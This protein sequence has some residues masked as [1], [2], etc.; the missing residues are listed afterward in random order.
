MKKDYE[1]KYHMLEDKHWW[2]EARRDMIVRLLKNDDKS[3]KI[4]EVGCSGG[5]LI[6]VL[7]R[8]G[9]KNVLGVDISEDAIDLCK[10][11]NMSDVFVMDAT[12]LKFENEQF[13][14]VI[15]SDLLEHIKDEEM[16]ISEWHRILKPGGKLI[17]FVPAFGF[18][19]SKHDEAN[20]H[21]RRY[22]KAQLVGI[23]E[24]AHFELDRSSYWNFILFFPT[25]LIR[26]L[27]AVLL[28]GKGSEDD[29]LIELD[30][31]SNKV[32]TCL[33]KMENMILNAVNFPVGVS[34][35]AITRKEKAASC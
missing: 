20:Q 10:R 21:Y 27:Q 28:R 1:I 24:R 30:S 35:F 7:R 3:V 17:V 15:T 31:V 23:L 13:D 9:Y 19:W 4:L 34:V 8:I 29:Q 25:S 14:I 26:L 22:S 12:K 33:V 16:A 5:V 11:K 18:L 6:G 32:L 2:F